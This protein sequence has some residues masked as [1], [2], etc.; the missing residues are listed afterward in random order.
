MIQK[1]EQQTKKDVGPA[2]PAVAASSASVSNNDTQNKK[3]ADEVNMYK[4]KAADSEKKMVSFRLTVLESRHIKQCLIL[5]ILS[6]CH[7]KR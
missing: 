6:H 1:K 2:K 7:I 3:M 4:K 5:G